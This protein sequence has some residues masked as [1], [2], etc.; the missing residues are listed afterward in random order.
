IRIT[1]HPKQEIS[2]EAQPTYQGPP[3]QNSRWSLD[4]QFRLESI[5]PQF[6]A[7]SN[8][9]A[10]QM[11]SKQPS[12]SYLPVG[13][14]VTLS[15]TVQGGGSTQI[16]KYIEAEGW[17][18]FDGVFNTEGQYSFFLT[19]ENAENY[20]GI[21]QE[22]LQYNGGPF[23]VSVQSIGSYFLSNP[24]F[25]FIAVCIIV[26]P[27]GAGL[28]YRRYVMLPKRRRKLAKY[29]AIADTFSDVAN[30][31]RLLVLHKESGICVFDPFAAES[32]DATLV[33]GF[34]QAISTFGHDLADSPGLAN[35]EKEEATLRELTYEGFRI[36]IHDGHFVRNAIVLSGQP[37][38]QLRT[39]L[40][41]FT[42]AF[43][44][45]YRKDFENW[46]GRVD[47]FNG[48]SDLV[49]EIFLISLRHPHSV[50]KRKPRNVQL[51]SLESDIYKLS[52]E[53]TLDREYVFLGQ[54]LSTYLTAAK[55][56][57]REALM[58]IYQLR[59]KGVYRPIHLGPIT[60]PDTSAA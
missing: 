34:L 60:P 5:S 41:N 7:T 37:S 17:V 22:A 57:K 29:Q 49:E 47:Q 11:P 45:R 14:K 15:I 21:P 13:T 51:T 58:A 42:T 38:D 16:E 40:E 31:N 59:I 4:L 26:I 18:H 19:I 3:N 56:D 32:Q 44:K 6:I 39:R 27:L 53:L 50:A 43:E 28:S 24:L 46:A 25:I 9:E 36:L 10:I 54:I 30:L 2:Y 52:K 12:S 35:R 1:I 20:A 23:T 55:T 33:A 48:A 8:S